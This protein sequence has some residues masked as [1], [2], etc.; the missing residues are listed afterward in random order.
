MQLVIKNVETRDTKN[1]KNKNT[2]KPYTLNEFRVSGSL[3]GA[4]G[5][6]TLKAFGA[7]NNNPPVGV[8]IEVTASEFR[9]RKEYLAAAFPAGG[10]AC[11]APQ[12]TAAT[13]GGY[14]AGRPSVPYTFEEYEALFCHAAGFVALLVKE[15]SIPQ[16]CMGPLTSTYIIGAQSM[17]LKVDMDQ[18]PM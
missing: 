2:G 16:E 7:S 13:A 14:R 9:G 5:T 10:A 11:T 18:L 12:A 3:D 4:E 15:N 1:D 8:P 17:G 6:F